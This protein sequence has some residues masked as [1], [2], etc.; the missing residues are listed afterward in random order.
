MLFF[1]SFNRAFRY[2]L[3]TTSSSKVVHLCE[4][5]KKCVFLDPLNND[6]ISKLAG[7]LEPVTYENDHV[8]IKQGDP[9][10]NFYIIQEG[11]VKCTQM[12]ASG[13]EVELLYV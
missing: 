13:R 7:A 10:D 9:G 4:F 11:N 2:I 1:T 8:I 12:K 6:Q 3:A 5:L